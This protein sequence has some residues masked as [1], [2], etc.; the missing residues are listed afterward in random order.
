[1]KMTLTA[2]ATVLACVALTMPAVAGSAAFDHT[3]SV[4]ARVLA[5]HV[6][7]PRVDYASLKAQR[8]SLDAVAASFDAA[9]ARGEA[10]WTREQ[11][12][13]FWI[14]A[15]NAFTLRAIVDHYPIRSS[16]FTLQ[17]R[18]SIRQIGDV[19]TARGWRAGGR[20]VSLDDI[21]HKI[22]RPE[23]ND[24][25]I[26]FAV[27]C[28]SVGC[29]PLAAEPYRAAT[30]DAQLDAAGRRYLGSPQGLQAGGDTLRVSSIF[31]W[32]GEDFIKTYAPIAPAGPDP[33][34]RAVLGAVMRFGP[35]GAAS[36]AKSGRARV[37]FLDYDWSL[38]DVTR[39]R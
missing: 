16:L 21:E 15:Y 17:P 24:A 19:W 37:V 18:N 28:A 6:E 27:N 10:G 30:L 14:N 23:F 33:A 29:P 2:L 20:A 1:M 26:H 25:R 39:A 34:T 3:Y 31:K 12:M 36:L 35:S 5:A 32:Y 38:N 7:G 4:L 11:R 22:L 13:A 9:D 8:A